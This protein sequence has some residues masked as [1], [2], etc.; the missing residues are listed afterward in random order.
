MDHFYRRVLGWAVRHKLIVGAAR[1]R[2][3]VPHGLHRQA[4]GQRVRHRR[5]SRPVRRRRRAAGRHLARRDRSHLRR[6]PRSSSSPTREVKLVFAT[7]GPNGEANKSQWRVVT[8]PKSERPSVTLAGDQGRRAQG[9]R[10]RAAEDAKVNV[11]DPAFVEGAQTEAPIMIDVRGGSGTGY[12]TLAPVAEA[13]RADPAHDAGRAGRA[14]QVHAGPP[15]A[16][17]RRRSRARHRSGLVGRRRW[18]WPCAPRWRATKR[19]K[20]R[21]GK[22]EIPIRVRLRKSDRADAR[23]I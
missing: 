21:Q 6:S 17:R 4:H 12:D 16:A 20:L 5:G 13:G 19:R 3:P 10:R 9:G 7:I 14:G 11:T 23:A 15:R 22:D 18:R 2:R 8:T 1:A